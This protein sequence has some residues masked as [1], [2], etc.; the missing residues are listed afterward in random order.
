MKR[1][2]QLHPVWKW[3]ESRDGY[4]PVLN[5]CPLP[6]DEDTLFISARFTIANGD[7]FDG[8]VVGSTTLYAFFIFC[9]DKSY[10][11]NLNAATLNE[12]SKNSLAEHLHKP[13]SEVFPI[14]Y[15]TEFH[16]PDTPPISGVMPIL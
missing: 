4:I 2:F 15:A 12:T 11:F 3:N 13:V 10:G 8:Y 1:D 14:Q 6:T 9:D 16:F 5:P 7:Y